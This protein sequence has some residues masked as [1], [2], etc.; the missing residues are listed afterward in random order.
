MTATANVRI[1][2]RDFKIKCRPESIK[3]LEDAAKYLDQKMRILRD[4]KD[5]TIANIDTIAIVSALNV[6]HDFLALR[7]EFDRIKKIKTKLNDALE[8]QKKYL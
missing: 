6:T 2:G 8:L 1:F 7:N 4:D 5:S 3:D